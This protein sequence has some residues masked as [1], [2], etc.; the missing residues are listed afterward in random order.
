MHAAGVVVP[1]TLPPLLLDELPPEPPEGAPLLLPL[2]V[3][4]LL[5]LPWRRLSRRRPGF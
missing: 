2:G 4:P 1:V 5:E 3:A